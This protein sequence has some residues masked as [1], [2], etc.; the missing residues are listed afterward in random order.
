MKQNFNQFLLI[1]L[2]FINSVF[3]QEK[4]ISNYSCVLSDNSL[5]LSTCVWYA[6]QIEQKDINNKIDLNQGFKKI[7]QF[8]LFLNQIFPPEEYGKLR[9]FVIYTKISILEKIQ[10]K[11]L[12]RFIFQ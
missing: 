3:A 7:Q 9:Y 12:V 8:P 11:H 5:D 2:L 6:K 10:R 1:I 4:E